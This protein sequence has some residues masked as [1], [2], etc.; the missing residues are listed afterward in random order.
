MESRQDRRAPWPAGPTGVSRSATAADGFACAGVRLFGFF[1]IADI[2]FRVDVAGGYAQRM[3]RFERAEGHCDFVPLLKT[4]A[5]AEVSQAFSFLFGHV[6]SVNLVHLCHSLPPGRRPGIER[7][8]RRDGITDLVVIVDG[9]GGRG[10]FPD[11]Q[12]AAIQVLTSGRRLDA[13]TGPAGAG[14]TATMKAISTGWQQ[15]HGPGSVVALAPAAVS[16]DVLGD[17]LGIQAENVAKWLYESDGPGAAKR[18]NGYLQAEH[19]LKHP[20]S[21]VAAQT[22]RRRQAAQVLAMVTAEQSR[23]QFYPGQLVIIDEASMVSTY[24]LAALT[25]QA[26]TA[27]AKLVLVGDPAQLDSIDA[28]GML[29]WLGSHRTCCPADLHAPLR[30]PLGSAPPRSSC[31]KGTSTAC[32]STSA[33][34]DPGGQRRADDRGRL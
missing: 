2:V 14:K 19:A 22:W 27:G 6:V 25:A 20:P 30:P 17:V 23:W 18:A 5:A 33:A 28:G 15:V 8:H 7:C 21:L 16:A 13:V 31:G 3:G 24:Q 10:L 1:V 32:W 34:E 12:D 9:E 29:G 11:Q 26:T 4:D